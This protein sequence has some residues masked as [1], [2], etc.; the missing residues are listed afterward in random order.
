[1]CK[2]QM[3][4]WDVLYQRGRMRGRNTAEIHGNICI[5]SIWYYLNFWGEQYLSKV[6]I[7]SHHSTAQI[8]PWFSIT[9]TPNPTS[10]PSPLLLVY[11]LL[12]LFIPHWLPDWA[13][14]VSFPESSNLFFPVWYPVSKIFRW[15]NPLFYSSICSKVTPLR[16]S[17][18]T[19]LP[20]IVPTYH[21]SLWTLFFSGSYLF[22]S[23]QTHS[24]PP[25]T[26]FVLQR[27]ILKNY[28]SQPLYQLASS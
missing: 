25:S 12:A 13:Q 15:L 17:F 4:L 2:S 7:G 24:S 8:F 20:K 28:I 5:F 18:L 1:M 6:L 26:L 9:F 21:L 10:R 23:S 14:L 19:T 22:V 3:I 16:R 11:P 27:L